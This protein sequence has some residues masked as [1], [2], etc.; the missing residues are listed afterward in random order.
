VAEQKGNIWRGVP[1]PQSATLGQDRPITVH[2][3]STGA[4]Q[5]EV[6][7]LLVEA[8]WD[9]AREQ[10]FQVVTATPDNSGRSKEAGFNELKAPYLARR[11]ALRQQSENTMLY[12]WELRSGFPNPKGYS[13]WPR[14]FD[15]APLVDAIDAQFSSQRLAGLSVPQLDAN[16]LYTAALE[17]GLIPAGKEKQFQQFFEDAA[18][19]KADATAQARAALAGVASGGD[20]TPPGRN[21]SPQDQGAAE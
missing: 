9:E 3:A 1:F 5:A 13:V 2:D 18:Q 14:E 21:P 10:S 6:S 4:V 17:R 12:F 8:K 19:Q 11:A 15:I 7:K 16:M 20:N